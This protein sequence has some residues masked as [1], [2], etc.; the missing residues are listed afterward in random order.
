MPPS[1]R[2]KRR[3]SRTR[4]AA[5]DGPAYDVTT[6]R[7][8]IDRS[9]IEVYVNGYAITFVDYPDPDHQ[10]LRIIEKNP[11]VNIQSMDIW[12]IKSMWDK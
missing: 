9:I 1:P 3:A 7:V 8:F 12:E 10:D 6:L 5:S 4:A 11:A 2:I